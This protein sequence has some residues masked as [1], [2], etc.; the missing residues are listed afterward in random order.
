MRDTVPTDTDDRDAV[1]AGA[2]G[3]E[4]A[5]PTRDGVRG[6]SLGSRCIV[7]GTSNVVGGISPTV[8]GMSKLLGA[9][10]GR[11]SSTG[12]ACM[13]RLLPVFDMP[14]TGAGADPDDAGAGGP[15][16]VLGAER[17]R[18]PDAAGGGSAFSAVAPGASGCQSARLSFTLESLLVLAF[19]TCSGVMV[20]MEA[21]ES[22]NFPS[23]LLGAP[24]EEVR[25]GRDDVLP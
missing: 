25:R 22:P 2:G 12:G 15:L 4:E 20:R 13:R 1:G 10:N 11:S 9:P 24:T 23:L 8:G 3:A 21:D 16:P 5:G 17:M 6:R 18:P 7:G 19:F 14:G